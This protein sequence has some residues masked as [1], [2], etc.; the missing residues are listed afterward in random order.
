MS[1][2]PLLIDTQALL[3][4]VVDEPADSRVSDVASEA[5][6]DS[7]EQGRKLLVSAWSIVELGYGTEKLAGN[8]G[9]IAPAD[10]QDVLDV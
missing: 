4:W 9:R 5:M 2:R 7:L 6:R 8:P 1:S 10:L 3:W